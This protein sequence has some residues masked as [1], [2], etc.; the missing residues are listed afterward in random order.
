MQFWGPLSPTQLQEAGRLAGDRPDVGLYVYGKASRDLDFLKYFEGVRRLHLA[1]YELEEI[2]GLSHLRN[3]LESLTFSDTKRKFS[4]RFLETMPQLK[5]LFLVGHKADLP[6]VQSLAELED[7]GLSGITLPDLSLLSP[8]V[9]LRKLA[10]LL[11]GTTNLAELARLSELEDLFLMRITK[12]SDLRV[13]GDVV[14]LKT[15][16]LDCIRNVTS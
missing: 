3:R 9:T 16:R 7:L 1:L 6:S 2:G 15:L 11:G 5:K 12:L 13:L 4:L 14:N 8:L 10:L